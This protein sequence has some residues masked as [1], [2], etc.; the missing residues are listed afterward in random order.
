[1][2]GLELRNPLGSKSAGVAGE[3]SADLAGKGAAE[4]V[5]VRAA[6]ATVR[7]E[8]SDENYKARLEASSG[9][10]KD[11]TPIPKKAATSGWVPADQ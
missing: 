8:L 9:L 6:V 7:T 5:R 10:L 2:V 3:F 1:V 4:T 11:I